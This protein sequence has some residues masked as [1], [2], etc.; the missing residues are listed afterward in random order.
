MKFKIL[1]AL[2]AIAMLTGCY[3]NMGV[4]LYPVQG[5]L[6]AKAP[7]PVF[8]AMLTE[9]SSAGEIRLTLPGGEECQGSFTRLKPEVTQQGETTVNASVSDG[10]ASVWDSVYGQ[11]FYVAHVLG[12][13]YHRVGNAT[14]DHGTVLKIEF[15]E[16]AERD[17]VAARGVARDNHQ[18]IYKIVFNR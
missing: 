16:M 13:Q 2:L 11:G 5:P 18:N 1:F 4:R 10:M 3:A 17:P 6:A 14:G 12:S 15:V 7:L 8:P 9:R